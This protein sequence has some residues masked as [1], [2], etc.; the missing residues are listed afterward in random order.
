MERPRW[1]DDSLGQNSICCDSTRELFACRKPVLRLSLAETAP[2]LERYT[3]R[4][5]KQAEFALD[6]VD[7][8]SRHDDEKYQHSRKHGRSKF[9]GVVHVCIPK[10]GGE[11]LDLHGPGA[12]RA[13]ARDL[14]A[15][16]LSFVHPAQV[17]VRHLIVGI[18]V[19]AHETKWF[20]AEVIRSREIAETDFWEYGVAFRCRLVV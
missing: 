10:S 8:T 18:E 15:G 17:D 1:R 13:L 6:F 14:S 7:R 5:K 19:S 4:Q 2:S 9:R 12:F 3:E 16:G 11:I 20:H